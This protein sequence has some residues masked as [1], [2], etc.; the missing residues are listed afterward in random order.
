M[1]ISS[2][3]LNETLAHKCLE[4]VSKQKWFL[5]ERFVLLAPF[6]CPFLAMLMVKKTD[7]WQQALLAQM[8][9]GDLSTLG[10]MRDQH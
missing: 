7:Q 10:S 9:Y 8:L 5:I 4:I 1:L 6:S 2:E 3:W